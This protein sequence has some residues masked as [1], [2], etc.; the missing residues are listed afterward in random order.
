M[1]DTRDHYNGDIT[2]PL[3]NV[4]NQPEMNVLMPFLVSDGIEG[5]AMRAAGP[6]PTVHTPALNAG[7]TTG[8]ESEAY[9]DI[10][11][12]AFYARWHQSQLPLLLGR[13]YRQLCGYGT[14]AFVVVPDPD[15]MAAKIEFRD[16]LGAYPALR[17]SEEIR[18]PEDIG[19]VYG[20]SPGWICMKYPIARDIVNGWQNDH[21]EEQLWDVVEWIDETDIVIGLLGP[22]SLYAQDMD[23]PVATGVMPVAA[24]LELKRIPNKAGVCSAVVPRRVTLDRIAGQLEKIIPMEEWSAKLMALDFVAAERYVFP[25]MVVIGAEGRTPTQVN[26]GGWRDGRTGDVNLLANV[27]SVQQLQGSPGPMTQQTLDRIERNARVSGGISPYFGNETTGSLRTGRAIDALGSYAVDPRIAELQLIMEFA[28]TAVN[29]L[30][31]A[32]EKGYFGQSKY[33]VFSGW[34]SDRGLVNYTPNVH[35]ETDENAVSY[36]FPGSDISQITVAVTQL[37]GAK[38]MSRAT[39]RDKHPFIED[40]TM[41]NRL[42]TEEGIDDAMLVALEQGIAS[43]QVS[44]TA[45]ASIK[46][47]ISSGQPWPDAIVAVNLEEQQKQQAAAQA[48]AQ[49]A[50]GGGPGGPGEN[51]AAPGGTGVDSQPG[52]GGGPAPVASIPPP[53]QGTLN[54]AAM[55]R[56]LHAGTRGPSGL[57]ATGPPPGG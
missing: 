14:N 51:L 20:R 36:T 37:N 28:L 49:A 33:T 41:E 6:M 16:A 12:R 45:V 23:S 18:P 48:Q 22:R 30:I 43:G 4:E 34:P 35:F 32:T 17:S 24:G 21:P 55:T 27:T 1:V 44:W 38:L 54:L 31:C 13:A 3:V 53:G 8:K 50:Q 11:R 40:A 56:A 7:K 57:A 5:T 26:G 19:F 15:T 25:D 39:A 10:R 2:I 46:Q 9:A 52:L 47:K 29:K 42:V